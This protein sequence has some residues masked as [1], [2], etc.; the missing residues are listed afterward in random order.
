MKTRA[1]L[2]PVQAASIAFGT[3]LL[4]HA[5]QISNG[6]Y[7]PVALIA[8]L[9]G[10]A[11]VLAGAGRV[12]APR[13]SEAVLAGVLAAGLIS[14]LL[15]LATMPVGFY[16]ADPQPSAHPAFLAGLA[17]AALFGLLIVVNPRHAARW[18]F[19]GLLAT[20]AL[21]GDWLIQASPRPH[22][23]VMTVFREALAALGRLESPY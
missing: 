20:A 6:F 10:A 5:L 3:I 9:L 14:N 18:W 23:D 21:L 12:P 13:G 1:A 7:S 11:C 4:G 8:A 15:A 17:A 19:P 2:T 22:I 16:L